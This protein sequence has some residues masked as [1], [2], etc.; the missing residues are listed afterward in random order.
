[1]EEEDASS[2]DHILVVDVDENGCRTFYGVPYD[3]VG[4]GIIDLTRADAA[5]QLGFYR[6]TKRDRE[7][8]VAPHFVEITEQ[9]FYT[10]QQDG[11]CLV[12]INAFDMEVSEYLDQVKALRR[13]RP[14][15][16]KRRLS[17]DD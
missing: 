6:V 13:E 5:A 8:D 12:V 1:M 11:R 16:A 7:I 4:D 2:F 17:F 15:R 3:V 14:K 9:A 10:M